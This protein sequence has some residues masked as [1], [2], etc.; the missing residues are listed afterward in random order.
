MSTIKALKDMKFYYQYCVDLS[1]RRIAELQ[2]RKQTDT[3][4][5]AR[6][7]A[8]LDGS[9]K[10]SPEA[11]LRALEDRKGFYL[12]VPM[13]THWHDPRSKSCRLCAGLTEA[14]GAGRENETHDVIQTMNPK[15]PYNEAVNINYKPK[16]PHI[17]TGIDT[18]NNFSSD[19]YGA[20]DEVN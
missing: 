3:E 19:K 18:I 9:S 6:I 17:S 4:M 5:I 10:E 13:I 16:F 12:G 8:A 15:N 11:L 14:A 1:D 20:I 2:S 7:D